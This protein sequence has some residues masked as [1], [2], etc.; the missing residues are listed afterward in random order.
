MVALPA[1]DPDWAPGP[2]PAAR[3]TRDGDLVTRYFHLPVDRPALAGKR[4]LLF[5][6]LHWSRRDSRGSEQLVDAVNRVESDW[7]VFTGD[8]IRYLEH[9]GAALAI[10]GRM[11]AQRQRL[12]TL[13]N[14]ERHHRWIDDQR[15]RRLFEQAGF[16]L[17]VNE[18]WE[19]PGPDGPVFVGMDDFRLGDGH[20]VSGPPLPPDPRFVVRLA[21]CPDAVGQTTGL[22]LG[23]LVLCGH[24]HGGQIR[25]PRLGALYTSSHYGKT[26][27]YG[28]YRR[29]SDGARLYVSSGIGCTG[30]FLFRRRIHCPPEVAV[31]ELVPPTGHRT[32]CEEEH[33]S[34]S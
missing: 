9:A 30:S 27:E 31:I 7:I 28:W 14:W 11:S 12:A 4:L 5:T 8:L 29:A 6:D 2:V 33:A 13:G 23:Q 1:R 25:A 22:D 18:T 24:T 21:H 16:Q 32:A 17:L 10:L 3:T 20:I 34:C 15:W 19:D 26:F